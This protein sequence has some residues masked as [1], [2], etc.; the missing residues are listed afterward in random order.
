MNLSETLVWA[1]SGGF[2]SVIELVNA[3]TAT[4]VVSG[5]MPGP[6]TNSP[7]PP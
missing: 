2:E 7:P 4:T 5:W 1:I 3:S 6:V